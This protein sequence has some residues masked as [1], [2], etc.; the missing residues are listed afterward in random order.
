MLLFHMFSTG[1][2]RYSSDGPHHRSGVS[3]A[4]IMQGIALSCC[5]K[6]D[7][8]TVH[9]QNGS[10]PPPII[11][12]TR[13]TVHLLSTTSTMMVRFLL[14]YTTT[15]LPSLLSNHFLKALCYPSLLP[16]SHLNPHPILMKG[17]VI[18]VP[19]STCNSSIPLSDNDSPPYTIWV[20]DC[21]MHKVFPDF[22]ASIC[23]DT[24]L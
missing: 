12:L 2:F 4:K 17:I 14:V 21:S 1:F 15:T 18:L 22:S 13:V 11:N 24:Y 9:A 5:H 10:T 6:S 8:S 19:I 3:A 20:F 16:S 23:N 7:G